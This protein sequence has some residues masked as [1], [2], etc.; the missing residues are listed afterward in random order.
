MTKLKKVVKNLAK[1]TRSGNS[2]HAEWE[3]PAACLK[4]GAKDDVRFNG[5]EILWIFDARDDKGKPTKGH[6]KGKGDVLVR[7]NNG[8]DKKH[9]DSETIP[10]AS[11]FPFKGKPLLATAEIW[12][13]GWNTQGSGQNAKRV[14]GEYEHRSLAFAKPDPPTLAL[15]YNEETNVASMTYTAQHPNGAKECYDTKYWFTVGG[16][17]VKD[18]ETSTKVTQTFTQELPG[19]RDLGI[20]VFKKITAKARNR[21]FAGRNETDATKSLYVC[22]PNPPVCGKPALVYA[23]KDVLAT[24]MVRVPVSAEG[25]V[26]DGKTAIRPSVLRLERLKNSESATDVAGAASASGWQTV[27]TDNGT[28][29][30]LADTWANAVSQSGKFTWYRLVAIRDGYETQGVPVQASCLDVHAS[31]TYTGRAAIDSAV[32]GAD[33]RSVVLSISGKGASDNGYEV[34]WSAEIDAWESTE[35]PDMFETTSSTLVV[36]GLAEG[37]QYYFKARAYRFTADGSYIYGDYSDMVNATPFST[38]STVVLNGPGTTPRG[39]DMLLTWTYDTDTPQKEWRLVDANGTALFSGEGATCARLVKP[40]EYGDASSLALRVEMTT[41]GSN[42]AR[43]GLVAF[44]IADPPTISLT[45]PATIT[46]QPV[47]FAVASDTGDAVYAVLSA[48]G[49]SGTGLHGDPQQ[50]E[51]DTVWSGTFNPLWAESDGTRTATVE[52]P[53]GLELF[54]NAVYA[55]A[56][57]AN[58]GAT[59]LDSATATA[60]MKVNWSHKAQQPTGTVEVDADAR[61]A[62]VTV[63]AP[64]DYATGDR[65]DLYRVTTDGERRI[66]SN[67]PFGTAVTDRLAPFTHDGRNLAYMAVTRTAD[68]ASCASDDIEYTLACASLRLDWGPDYIE[69]PYDLAL[70]DEMGKNSEVRTHMDGTRQ[71][72]WNE[73]GT[74]KASITTDLVRFEDAAEREL[75]SGMLQYAGSVFVRTPDG[76]AYAADVQPGTV[77]RSHKSALEQVSLTAVEHDLTDEGRPG[78]ADIAE[79]AWNGGAVYARNGVVYDGEGDFPMD[80]WA[81]IGYASSTLYVADAD[82]TVRDGDG[83]EMQGWTFDGLTLYDDNGDE[84]EVTEEPTEEP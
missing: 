51:G 39:S 83:D 38:P 64:Q 22:H 46:A 5:Q 27:T 50:F 69:L 72:Y 57:T 4:N 37:V 44:N 32:S 31:G 77:S 23:T 10:R 56:V 78:K 68:G 53:A 70:S 21:G 40:D 58:D 15:S 14:Y 41:D 60:E 42:W 48:Q 34:T 62:T 81:F 73:G 11:F 13:R 20:G 54:D 30:G 55:L 52:L 84:M 8:K 36:K 71:A 76:L 35:P 74:R 29:K 82:N 1:P 65:F 19:G 45:A 67:Q 79:P 59:G 25:V 49:S 33:G 7:D 75:L 63:A 66:A 28:C 9:Q 18:G 16:T 80:D 12:V 17:K 47:S 2:V 6:K 43:S 61:T 24:A 26:K 3:V